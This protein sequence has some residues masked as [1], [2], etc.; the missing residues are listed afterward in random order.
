MEELLMNLYQEIETL[1]S[2][3]PCL[4]DCTPQDEEVFSDL[5]NL[6]NSLSNAGYGD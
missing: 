4:D 1:L 2:M 6:Y 3:A 5:A